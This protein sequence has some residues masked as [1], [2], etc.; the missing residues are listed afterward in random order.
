MSSP[1]TRLLL[2]CACIPLLAVHNANSQST[3]N[4]RTRPKLEGLCGYHSPDDVSVS[5]PGQESDS[6][7]PYIIPAKPDGKSY[8][9][10]VLYFKLED[11]NF[12]LGELTAD[13]PHDQPGPIWQGDFLAKTPY[14]SATFQTELAARPASLTAYFHQMSGGRLWLYGDEVTYTGPPLNLARGDS[15]T[16]YNKWA[17]TNTSILQWFADNYPLAQLDNNLDGLVD[18]I[19]LVC[20][21]RTDFRFQGIAEIPITR[22]ISVRS[23][24]PGITSQSGIYQKNNFSLAGTRHIVT[25]EIGHRLG[26][27]HE[28]G[29]HRWN[30]MSGNGERAPGLSGVTMS[31]WERNRLGWLDFEVVNETTRDINLVNLTQ[32]GRA[33]K[34]PIKGSSDFFVIENR[35]H[36]EPFE[37]EPS[38]PGTG[39]LFYYIAGGR[40]AIIPADGRVTRIIVRRF[41]ETHL[42]YQGDN[43][44]LFGNFGV[45]EITPYTYPGTQTPSAPFT[46]IALQDIRSSGTDL[47]F[48]VIH[49]FLEQGQTQAAPPTNFRMKNYPNPVETTTTIFYNVAAPGHVKLDVYNVLGQHITRLVDEFQESWDYQITFRARDVTPGVYFYFLETA[50]GSTAG[51]MVVMGRR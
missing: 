12:E 42:F 33:L 22:A 24:E 13:W 25:H 14:D 44:D 18:M 1:A 46:G 37:P 41:S 30:L 28:N 31:G 26:F 4:F 16:R 9:V 23:G 38:L 8:R 17:D 43:S 45:R 11:D 40:P 49:D 48:S 2:L 21:T 47:V 7:G 35:Q 50:G 10:A 27:A 34:V 5:A 19:I 36:S 15:L 39:L 29:L 20:R 3:D 51:K 32:S 6:P